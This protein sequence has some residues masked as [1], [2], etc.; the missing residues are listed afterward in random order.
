MNGKNHTSLIISRS[1]TLVVIFLIIILSTII[2]T[3]RGNS[4]IKN[5]TIQC[6]GDNAELYIQKGC[7]ACEKQINMLEGDCECLTIIDCWEQ[8]KKCI[9]NKITATPTWIIN[10][11]KYIGVQ[12]LEKLKELTNC[13]NK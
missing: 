8:R 3:S 2:I 4:H 5:E 1:I 7:H 11:E 10:E 13:K 9:T 12:S 6:I